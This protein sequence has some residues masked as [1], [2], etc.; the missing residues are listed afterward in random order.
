MALGAREAGFRHAWAIDSHIDSCA[1]YRYNIGCEKVIAKNVEEVDFSRLPDIDGLCFGFPCNDFSQVGE[2]KGTKGHFGSLYQWAA[3]ALAH[4]QPLFFIAENV[5]GLRSTNEQRD[6]PK[7]L[8]TFARAG[9]HGYAIFPQMY[10]LENYGVPQKRHRIFIMGLRQDLGL[11]SFQHPEPTGKT[12]TCREALEVPP[13]PLWATNNERTKHAPRVVERLA[14]IKPGENAFTADL[15]SHL[16]LNVKGATISQ[17]YRRL[18]PQSPAYTV[19]GSGGGG[20]HM[21]H[22]KENRALTNRERARL[23]TFP[24]TFEFMGGRESV[25]AQHACQGS[26]ARYN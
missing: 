10:H 25:R 13:I 11:A 16:R 21:Y 22:W 8:D 6:F 15:P 1:T 3:S 5:S 12:V 7:I 14:H 4:F 26:L 18:D 9:E 24:D 19:T 23:Q 17:I 2:R 20:T